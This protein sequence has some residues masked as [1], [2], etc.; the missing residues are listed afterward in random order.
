[1]DFNFSAFR[2]VRLVEFATAD[3]ISTI[4]DEATLKIDVA[5]WDT[6]YVQVEEPS[7]VVDL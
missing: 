7:L 2:H 5:V 6:V 1:M 3:L 4:I